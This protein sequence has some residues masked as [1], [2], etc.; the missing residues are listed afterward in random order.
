MYS[1]ILGREARDWSF[2]TYAGIVAE[3]RRMS[4]QALVGTRENGLRAT[5][6][7]IEDGSTAP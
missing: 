2:I 1:L 5:R 7:S 6:S 3:I 4:V